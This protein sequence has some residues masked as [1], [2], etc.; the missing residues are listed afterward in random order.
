M[1]SLDRPGKL[2]NFL[3]VRNTSALVKTLPAL[4]AA[5]LAAC[6]YTP[7]TLT[8][9]LDVRKVPY[10]PDSGSIAI[11]C[12]RLIDGVNDAA[13]DNVLVVVRDGR[14][15]SVRADA[16]HADAVATHFPILDL[17]DQ[18]CLPGLIDMHGHLT[19]RPDDTAD[20][21]VYFSRAA[22]E[23]LRQGKE[24]AAATLL[25]GFTSVR[26]VGTYVS[27][28]RHRAARRDQRR[29]VARPATPGQR[30]LSHDSARRRRPLRSR[31]RGAR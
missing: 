20:L 21:T 12:G 26:N 23:T 6:A 9:L 4:A 7:P 13:R 27:A 18:T 15:K 24:N 31:L 3:L 5:L 2:L 14:I 8:S 17:R 30:A 25:A 16:S 11:R 22:T 28:R 1:D 29:K 19:D 10:T